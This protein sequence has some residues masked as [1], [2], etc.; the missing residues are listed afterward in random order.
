MQQ[1]LE[2]QD[3]IVVHEEEIKILEVDLEE[4]Q[5][6]IDETSANLEQIEKKYKE[7]E[8][9]LEKRL[10]ALYQVGET[11]YLDVLLNSNGFI[12]FISNYYMI[13]QITEFDMDLLEETEKQKNMYQ[14]TKDKFEIDKA[15][16]KL[17]KAKKMQMATIMQ[18]SKALQ[19]VYISQLN[20][21]EV[22]L[23][24]QIEKYKLEEKNVE[25]MI[26][27]AL[28]LAT[29]YGLSYSG[30]IM[31]WPVVKEGSYITSDFGLREH[32]ITGVVKAHTGIDIS[33]GYGVPIISAA[34]GIVSYAG[35]LGGYG[36]CVIVSHGDGISTLYGHGQLIKATLNQQVKRGD[37]IMEMG[38]TGNSTGPHLHFEVR[39]NNTPTNPISFLKGE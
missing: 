26:A 37:L 28:S 25:A 30:G 22:G 35:W 21:Q 6:T 12:D 1:T 24:E 34:D 10:V 2:L 18:N 16:L 20:E 19:S 39:I 3:K 11:S 5:K 38:S 9:L 4:L 33:G 32:P 31:T 27:Q 8:E 13:S 23:R 7:Q 14:T 17:K 36:N 15:S 29:N